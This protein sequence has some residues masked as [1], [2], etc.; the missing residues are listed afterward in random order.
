MQSVLLA[1]ALVTAVLLQAGP[2]QRREDRTA[3]QTTSDQIAQLEQIVDTMMSGIAD[4]L[5]W[6]SVWLDVS[7]SVIKTYE[8]QGWDS[9]EDLYSLELL[10]EVGSI[11]PWQINERLDVFTEITA[12]RY[13]LDEE[14]A[15]EFRDILISEAGG[16]LS[17]HAASLMPMAIEATQ[18]YMSGDEFTP[19]Q[20]ARWTEASQPMFDDAR[21]RIGLTTLRLLSMMEPEQRE[22][23]M[24]DVA[25]MNRRLERIVELREAARRGEWDPAEWGID[26][27]LRSGRYIAEGV[28]P[29]T[30]P[31]AE[32][33]SQP[34]SQPGRELDPWAVYVRDFIRR[35]GLNEAQQRSAWQTY[36]RVREQR[37][38][39]EH[40]H[41][42]R[43]DRLRHG[44]A[45]E[46]DGLQARLA[47]LEAGKEKTLERLFDLLKRRLNRLPTRA[48]RRLVDAD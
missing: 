27:P 17:K 29:A 41:E 26:G 24:A 21:Q 36:R 23:L 39:Q 38:L 44:R 19:E 18:V 1:T 28:A 46:D 43:V 12:D 9:E 42:R 45:G 30:M 48:Q 4:T 8:R 32:A 31:A 40:Q 37:E 33:A 2:Q 20:I 3:E 25:A 47:K 5:E 13:L 14:Q 11:P 10:L 22:W 35:Y 15:G 6:D 7:D 34:A 16:L